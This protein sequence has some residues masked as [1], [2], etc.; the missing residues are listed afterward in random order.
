M[1]KELEES[2]FVEIELEI[3]AIVVVVIGLIEFVVVIKII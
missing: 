1:V 3:D 2:L